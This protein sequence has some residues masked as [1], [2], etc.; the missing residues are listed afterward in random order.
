MS[1]NLWPHP[2]IAE[3]FHMLDTISLDFL[4]RNA[5]LWWTVVVAATGAALVIHSLR[6]GAGEGTAA[7]TPRRWPGARWP[8]FVGIAAVLWAAAALILPPL[9]WPLAA[10]VGSAVVMAIA[11]GVF[12]RSAFLS[13]GPRRSAALLALRCLGTGFLLLLL[14]KPVLAWVRTPRHLETLGMVI[15]ASGSMSVNDQPNEPSR[16]L[17]SVMAAKALRQDLQGAFRMEYFAYDGR[18]AAPLA[19]AK[20]WTAIAPRG[21]RTDLPAAIKLAVN[22]GARD[23][24][25]FS[26]GIQNGPGKISALSHLR[27]PVY[28]VLV[29]STATVATTIPEIDIVN[30]D[31]PQTAPVDTRVTLRACVKSYALNDRTVDVYLQYEKKRLQTRHLV[32]HSGPAQIVTFHFTPKKIGRMELTVRIP[33]QP[34]ERTTAGNRQ[35]FP[36]LITN[37]RIRVLYLE[38]RVRPETGPL[39]E[40]L[41]TDPN[42]RLVSL[43]QVAPG[44]FLVR[45]VKNGLTAVPTTA[46]Q[47]KPFKVIILGDISA[48]FLSPIQQQ[49]LR[50]A[51]RHGAGFLMIGGE[52]NFAAGDWGQSDMADVFPVSLQPV[53]PAQLNEPFVPRLTAYGQ[54]SPILRGI[55][56]WFLAPGGAAP[57]RRL[58][59]LL[60]CVAFA[61]A[62]PAA[63]VLLDDPK[64]KVHGAPAIVLAVAHYGK[65]RTAAFAADTTYRWNLGLES[66]GLA[67]PYHRFWGQLVRWLA[68]QSKMKTPGG[69]GVTA[70]LRRLRYKSGQTVHL[71]AS[72]TDA[73]GQSTAYAQV[74]AVI[75]GPGGSRPRRI[76]LHT[77]QPV[78]TYLARYRPEGA[79]HYHVIFTA[80]QHGRKLGHA[81]SDFYVITPFDEMEK[82]AAE[83]AELQKIAGLTGGGF[84]KISDIGALARRIRAAAPAPERVERS[85]LALYDNKWFFILFVAA[86]TGEWFL[87]RKWRL[88]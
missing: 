44:R 2:L 67:S 6:K 60:G 87:R 85:S 56:P 14:F 46:R 61:G 81:T 71:R 41:A 57:S 25:L 72:V 47:W 70:L 54:T 65:G 8:L 63:T 3:S 7:A 84:G 40:D 78:G 9:R 62:Q 22:A 35:G 58:P 12:Y 1:D 31:G 48:S 64:A 38:A 69:A 88:R 13:L 23:V 24:V 74:T 36:I 21:R 59:H 16:Y 17:Q 39:E 51:V 32:L 11:F 79:G 27:V 19:S 28:T 37:P 49:Q 34:A 10:I 86:L 29:G 66:M 50:H 80:Y 73:Q 68:G 15:D 26:D 75:N 5:F 83:P 18:H 53:D 55:T 43:I 82:L 76:R 42:V 77:S 52:D 30:I 4:G 45:G 20:D 33:S